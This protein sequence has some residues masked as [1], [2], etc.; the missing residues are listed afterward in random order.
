MKRI[1]TREFKYRIQFL[2]LIWRLKQM[3]FKDLYPGDQT[4]PLWPAID[5]FDIIRYHENIDE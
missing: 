1:K 3:T 4:Y 2:Y 5:Y